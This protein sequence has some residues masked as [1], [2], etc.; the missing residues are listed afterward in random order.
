MLREVAF[1]RERFA[2]ARANVRF[3]CRVR[4]HMRAQ[5]RLVCKR[6]GTQ[7]TSERLLASVSANVTLKQPRSAEALAAV[8]AC[9]ALV[10]RAHVH[11]EG[12][13]ADV[14]F[15]TVRAFARLFVVHV[16][17]YLLVSRQVAGCTVLLAT[18]AT[19]VHVTDAKTVENLVNKVVEVIE[20]DIGAVSWRQEVTL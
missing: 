12:R 10:V 11:A 7:T 19:R 1:Q 4:L 18:L 17:V 15:L 3:F 20:V 9:A 13:H 16:A 2:A 6:L 8:R 14:D 5:V